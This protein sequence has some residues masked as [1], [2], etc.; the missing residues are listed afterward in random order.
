MF[1]TSL[2]VLLVEFWIIHTNCLAKRIDNEA[3][4]LCNLS[5]GLDS[6]IFMLACEMR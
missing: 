4:V 2:K 1:T 6:L 5:C 3:L